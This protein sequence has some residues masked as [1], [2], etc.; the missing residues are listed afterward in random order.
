VFT[1]HPILLGLGGSTGY[2]I[3]KLDDWTL[4][5]IEAAI[6]LLVDKLWIAHNAKFDW[7][8]LKYHYQVELP[9]VYCTMVNSQILYNG[10]D[11]KHSLDAC[12]E[13]HFNIKMNKDIRLSF[14]NWKPGDVI[15]N[16][17]LDYLYDDLIHLYP[18]FVRQQQKLR[19]WKLQAC[20]SLENKFL[21]VLAQMEL[22]GISLDVEKWNKN[23][24]IFRGKLT[25]Y[26]QQITIEV[27]QLVENVPALNQDF[28]HRPKNITKKLAKLFDSCETVE[29]RIE[30]I[31]AHFN[32]SSST[33]MKAIFAKCG[34]PMDSTNAEFLEAYV[35]DKPQGKLAPLITALLKH[36]EYSKLISTYGDNFLKY[37]N[38]VTKR[39]HSDFSQCFTAT[40]RLSSNNPN[41]QNLPAIKEIR[42][43][44]VPDSEDYVF[45][46][47]DL[48]NQELRLAASY[49]QDQ[50]LLDNFNKGMDLHSFLAQDTH[51][52]IRG[53][54]TFIVSKEV[55]G[56][57][58]DPH[59]PVLFGL[60]NCQ[61]IHYFYISK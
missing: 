6:T 25:E 56:E 10:S 34:E 42:Q 47:V 16:E 3:I 55:N 39:I 40:G 15:T 18:L 41:M 43:C 9:N 60:N 12:L 14:I 22:N 51:R 35:R 48:S 26:E 36:R 24:S 38:P 8:I 57:L 2:F 49:S 23:T 46:D 20:S 32:M 17:Q 31:M 50:A 29:E 1:L 21:P 4:K 58:R 5:E 61:K 7:K 45:V 13:R 44:F 30:L 27:R 11:L 54:P 53:D 33:Q 52:I 28:I 37:I 59:K 19:Q